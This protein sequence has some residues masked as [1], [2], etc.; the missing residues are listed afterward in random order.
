MTR[1]TRGTVVPA[2]LGC[3][4]KSG[5]A[6]AVLVE[7]PVR[8]PRVVDRRAIELSDAHVPTSR[9]P[10]HAVRDARPGQAARLERYLRGVVE[11]VSKRSLGALLKEYRR[12]GRR[13]R[14]VALVVGSLID[15]ARIGNDHI[16]A[17]ALEGQL[18]RTALERA[19]RAAR[20]PCTTLVERV[21]YETAAPRLKRSPGALRHAVKDLGGALGGP[22]RADEKA[23]TLAA[24]LALA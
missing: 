3:R 8:S 9:Q 4:V 14:R 23:A 21:L 13:V 17:H 6:T 1:R 15:P 7:G 20:L 24:W 16:R 11:R 10:Y 12:Q 18:F 19:A 2:A 5:W 22:W